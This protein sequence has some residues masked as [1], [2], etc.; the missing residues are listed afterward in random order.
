MQV[1]YAAFDHL[2]AGSAFDRW[3]V[4]VDDLD[5]SGPA[6]IPEITPVPS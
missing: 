5:R 4:P 1:R 2:E 6:R 3:P